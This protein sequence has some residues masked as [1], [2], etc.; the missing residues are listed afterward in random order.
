MRKPFLV[1]FMLIVTAA[2]VQAQDSVK[3]QTRLNT[4][5]LNLVSSFL[6]SNSAAISY[7]RVVK[8]Y[9]SWAVM[10]GY[11]QFPE[12]G[13]FGS[14]I[15]VK[16]NSSRNGYVVG[17]EYRFYMKK[18]NKYQAP[19]GVFIGPYTNFFS[20]SN[21][22]QLSLTAADG[23]TVTE[24]TL[25][26]NITALNIGFQLGYQ[27]VLHNRW[28]FDFVVFGPSLTRY[29]LK[30]SLDGDLSQQGILENEIA[31]AL[32]NKFPLIKDLLSNQTVNVHGNSSSWSTGFRY[33]LNV[34]YRF[35]KKNKK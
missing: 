10:L 19:H 21:E 7:E 34:G 25:N 26:T 11:V 6:Y 27:F 16:N 32:A 9:Q 17:G 18:E 5:K 24:A 23:V 30:A 3:A 2:I 4:I 20:F 35:G 8:P 29:G 22:R 13:D 33:Q 15:H 14:S 28:T 12:I 31:A 1:I